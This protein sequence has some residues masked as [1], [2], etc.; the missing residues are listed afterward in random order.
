MDL[1]VR[2]DRLAQLIEERL[3]I[4]GKGLAAKLGRGGRRLP[5]V[6]R[7]AGEQLLLAQ[8]MADTPKLARQINHARIGG[9]CDEAE[10]VLALIDPWERRRTFAINWLAG[11]A[12]NIL[13]VAVL[14]VAVIVWRG[15]L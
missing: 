3:D 6:V 4:R 14:A 12:F 10:R 8:R 11:N 13:V 7:D 9:L 5:R 15:L 1:Q 2:A